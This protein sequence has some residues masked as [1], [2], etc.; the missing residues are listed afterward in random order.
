MPIQIPEVTI[1]AR[2]SNED[3]ETRL[4]RLEKMIQVQP[5]GSLENV[6]IQA[7]GSVILSAGVGVHAAGASSVVLESGLSRVEVTPSKVGV[8]TPGSAQV[9]A[10]V[11]RV[12]SSTFAVNTA[13]ATYSGTLKANTMI[14]NVIIAATYTPGAGNVW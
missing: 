5:C 9:D 4:T 8:T 12:N 14:T 1:K 11:V 13:M 2:V 6:V 7:S 3:V 10:S